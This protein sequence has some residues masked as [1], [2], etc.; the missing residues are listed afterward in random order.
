MNKVKQMTVEELSSAEKVN[1]QLQ[2]CK[3][4]GYPDFIPKGG[5]CWKCHKQV[6]DHEKY[7]GKTGAEELVT[8]CP[9]CFRSYCD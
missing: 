2:M 3:E 6:Y 4:K 1:N 5:I 9:F 8:G 7:K